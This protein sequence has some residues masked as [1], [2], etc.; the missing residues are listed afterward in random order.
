MF[1]RRAFCTDAIRMDAKAELTAASTDTDQQIC[2]T[3]SGVLLR[4]VRSTGGEEAVAAL[5][6]RAGTKHQVPYLENTDNWISLD[7]A[8]AL[9]EAGV[10][11]TGDEMFARRV[12]EASVSQHVGTQVSTMLRSMGSVEAV[13]K[14]IAQAAG[15][16]STVTEMET[17]EAVP[18]HAV[19]RAVMR[20]GFT[21]R[22]VHCDWATGVL[23]GT[24]IL[25]GLPIARVEESECQARGDAQCLYTASWDAELAEMAADPQQR[26]TALEAQLAAM[27]ERLQSA[28][29]TAS[30]LISTED[31]DT[32]LRRIVERAAS[33]VR[34]P[35]HILAVRTEPGAELQVYS[36]GIDSRE[37]DVLALASI[38]QGAPADDSTLVVEVTSSRRHYGQLIAR[39][40]AAIQFFPQERE[41]L[42][43]YAKHAAAVLDMATAL[44]ESAQRHDQVSS[45]HSLSHALAQAGTS[46]EIAERLSVAVPEVV[47]C[48]RMA[49]WLWDDDDERL[50][51][52][53][54]WGRKREQAAYLL[55]LTI[56]AEDTPYLSRMAVEPQPVFFDESTEDPYLC[57]LMTMLEASVL[58][59]IPIVVRDVFLGALSVSVTDRPERLRPDSELVDRLTGVAA[60]AAPAIQN[61]RLVDKLRH[62]ANHDG[63]TGLLNPVGFRQHIGV[64]LDNVGPGRERVGLLFIDLNDFKA[65]ND[66]YGHEAGDELLS[67]AAG[68]MAAIS[69]GSDQ[70]A[71]LGGDEFAIIL[72]DVHRD[73]QVRAA[74]QRVRAAFLEP[75]M[76]GKISVSMSASVGGVVWPADGD[77]VNELVKRADAAM[78]KDKANLRLAGQR[79][80]RP[81]ATAALASR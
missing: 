42:G 78:Y 75:F 1:K 15:K 29:A 45:L 24:P 2:C 10:Q 62:N 31:L 58:A 74:E 5:L 77:T 7:D 54:V 18:G 63:L 32:V 80:P 33:A 3:M 44:Q 25:F 49:V 17:L 40:P 34:S 65:V 37:A 73:D 4:L 43:L 47:D 81:R 59:V 30:D 26:I 71:R 70:V 36:H 68:R 61:G 19:V 41:A 69:R 52:L 53:S 38:E 12:G 27:S 46:E 72:A 79:Q 28:Y 60:L 23:A 66:V 16:L 11:E 56:A 64:V 20:E 76:L 8:C 50:T 21:R 35:S 14:V 55:G 51:S 39:N 57:R 9:L 13:L 67:Q 22:K 6:T 48:D